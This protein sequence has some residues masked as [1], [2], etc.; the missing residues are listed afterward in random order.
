M[1][2]LVHASS[3]FSPAEMSQES[4]V[5]KTRDKLCGIKQRAK[6]S[7]HMQMFLNLVIVGTRVNRTYKTRGKVPE[8]DQ[9]LLRVLQLL[10]RRSD[11]LQGKQTLRPPV[12]PTCS[13]RI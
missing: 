8:L 1:F 2:P 6:R 12:L 7:I 13:P 4:L 5:R 10:H 11:H 3:P 9:E